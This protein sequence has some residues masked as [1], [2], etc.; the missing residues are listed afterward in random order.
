[1]SSRT[2]DTDGVMA[3]LRHLP[4]QQRICI[5]LFHVDGLPIAEIA[6]ALGL[7]EGAVKFHLHQGRERLRG[8]LGARATA[9]DDGETRS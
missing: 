4:K 9:D 7:S 2:G 3:M 5:A 1:M 6:S 8:S